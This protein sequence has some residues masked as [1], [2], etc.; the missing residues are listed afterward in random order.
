[1]AIDLDGSHAQLLH[2][3]DSTNTRSQIGAEKTAVGCFIGKPA[4]GAKT[5]IDGSGLPVTR[6]QLT[7]RECEFGIIPTPLSRSLAYLY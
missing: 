4:H 1:V 6:E 7:P 3:L 2:T 5:Q